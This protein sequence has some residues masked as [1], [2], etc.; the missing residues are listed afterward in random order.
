MAF[1]LALLHLPA[2]PIFIMP[3][4]LVCDAIAETGLDILRPT[5]EVDVKLGLTEDEL[6]AIAPDYDAMMVR[7]ATKIT[8]RVLEAASKLANRWSRR[9]RRGQH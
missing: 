7:S 3:K 4:V 5:L 9:S 2:V 6:V 8:R 1:I